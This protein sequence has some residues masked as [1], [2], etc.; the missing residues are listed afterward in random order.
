[1]GGCSQRLARVGAVPR[2]A[3]RAPRNPGLRFGYVPQKLAVEAALPL[4]VARFLS[5]P[6]RH[7]PARIAA[8][9]TSP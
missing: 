1:M 8:A 9:L 4:N 2:A 7:P 6:V 3:G 5:L